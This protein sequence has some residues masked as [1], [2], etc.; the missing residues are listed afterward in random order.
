MPF[1]VLVGLAWAAVVYSVLPTGTGP[2]STTSSTSGMATMAG[3]NMSTQASALQ[4]AANALPMWVVM[5]IAMMLPGALPALTYVAHRSYRWRRRRAM[6]TFA[7][8]Y[9]S[10]WTAF[11]A[12]AMLV[13]RLVGIQPAIGI[14]GVLGAGVA[15]QL[16]RFKR[17]ALRDCHRCIP[18]GASGWRAT[19][20]IGRFGFLHGWAC[21]R[22][23]WPAMLAMA[24]VPSTE[25]LLLMMFLT[26]IMTAEKLARQPQRARNIV[27]LALALGA[28]IAVAAA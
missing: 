22:S 1:E 4:H 20:S 13:A 17:Q 8:V 28:V 12:V 21:I 11:G 2:G 7:A 24:I 9:L 15:W 18:L 10:L 23:C 26:A 19:V 6:A 14:A 16:T 25:M 3:M 5:S 27:S